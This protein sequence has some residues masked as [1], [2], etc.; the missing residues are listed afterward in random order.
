MNLNLNDYVSK[1]A[2][3]DFS[4]TIGEKQYAMRRPIVA[5]LALLASA[6]KAN[7]LDIGA[8]RDVLTDLFAGEKPDLSSLAMEFLVL[9][10]REFVKAFQESTKKNCEAMGLGK[11]KATSS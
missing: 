11:T 7:S 10:A 9:I 3:W 2:P 1:L 6:E 8:L 4:V 5:D